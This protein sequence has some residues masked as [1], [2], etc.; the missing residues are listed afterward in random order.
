VLAPN[1]PGCTDD[2]NPNADSV[3]LVVPPSSNH[4]GGV[5]IAR[6]DGSIQFISSSIDTGNVNSGVVQP[7]SGPSLYGVWGALGSKSGGETASISD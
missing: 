1:A 4:T 6:A 7:T 3:N 2:A 5:N